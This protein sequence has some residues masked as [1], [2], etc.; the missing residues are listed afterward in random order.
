M[1]VQSLADGASLALRD[2]REGASQE[3]QQFGKERP[4]EAGEPFVEDREQGAAVDQDRAALLQ[5]PL[6][7]GGGR[8]RAGCAGQS[9]AKPVAGLLRIEGPVVEQQSHG[10]SDDAAMHMALVGQAVKGLLPDRLQVGLLQQR[11]RGMDA[12]DPRLVGARCIVVEALAGRRQSCGGAGHEPA[13]HAQHRPRVRRAYRAVARQFGQG[14]QRLHEV[15][16]V[17]RD[18]GAV[19][20]GADHVVR[21]SGEIGVEERADEARQFRDA[22]RLARLPAHPAGGG[23][24]HRAAIGGGGDQIHHPFG[25]PGQEPRLLEGAAPARL[26][27]PAPGDVDEVEPVEEMTAGEVVLLAQVEDE[28]ARDRLRL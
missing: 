24:R 4:V 3:G 7:P 15:E 10:A 5:E 8:H 25:L 17:R 1:A 2:R 26:L 12:D 6:D 13:H 18:C 23:L 14:R 21:G 19:V 22:G 28:V 20:E 27:T 11:D 16:H 9:E